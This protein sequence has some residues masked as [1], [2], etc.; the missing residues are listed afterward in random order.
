MAAKRPKSRRS[1][2]ARPSSNS[3]PPRPTGPHRPR[4]S[5]LAR[6]PRAGRLP[7]SSVLGGWPAEGAAVWLAGG[8]TENCL[9]VKTFP[10]VP[11]SYLGAITTAARACQQSRRTVGTA[12]DNCGQYLAGASPT[13]P[14]GTV[15]EAPV[16]SFL[17]PARPG[18]GFIR[19]LSWVMGRFVRL[20]PEPAPLVRVPS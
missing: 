12:P 9:T 8:I 5:S 20:G 16:L 7:V 3:P 15:G 14:K 11:C 19:E 6:G 17:P 13:P 10:T 4:I 2:G 1:P 18:M